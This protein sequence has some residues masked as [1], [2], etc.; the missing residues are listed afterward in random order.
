MFS[1]RSTGYLLFIAAYTGALV[2]EKPVFMGVTVLE[3]FTYLANL[4][5]HLT[6]FSLLVWTNNSF[7]IPNLLE[8]KFLSAYAAALVGLIILYATAM[9][10]YNSFLEHTIF[11]YAS[12]E[13]S[14][15]Y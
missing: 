4:F 7:L 12:T 15:G 13:T 2:V 9:N 6:I 5:T 10:H 11:H 14:G 8:K 1:K 3:C